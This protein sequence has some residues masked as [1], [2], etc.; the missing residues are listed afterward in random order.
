MPPLQNNTAMKQIT[1]IIERNSDGEYSVYC[2]DEIFSGMGETAEA[3]KEDM[4]EAI[5]HYVDTCRQD[6]YQYPKWLDEEY[7]IVYKFDTQSLLQYYAGIITPAALGRLSGINPKQ[8]WSY[9]HGKSK[10]R[11]AQ[12]KKIEEALHKLGSELSSISL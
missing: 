6:G 4:K 8:L 5:R 9:A 2:T 1:A 7:E 3:A 10:P 12:V 11:E